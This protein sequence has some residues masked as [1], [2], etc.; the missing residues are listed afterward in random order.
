MEQS[1]YSIVNQT[2][3]INYN[4]EQKIYIQLRKTQ[5]EQEGEMFTMI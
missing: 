1:R 2:F 3:E 4:I 5:F